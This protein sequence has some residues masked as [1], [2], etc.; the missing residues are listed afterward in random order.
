M[1]APANKSQQVAWVY[2]FEGSVQS[3]DTRNGTR[4]TQGAVLPGAPATAAGLVSRVGMERDRKEKD[5][6]EEREGGKEGKTD[7]GSVRGWGHGEESW[8]G[9]VGYS[10]EVRVAT[11]VLQ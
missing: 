5:W 4:A 7:E 10:N 3:S 8:C 9:L 2:V 11:L 6:R 1:K